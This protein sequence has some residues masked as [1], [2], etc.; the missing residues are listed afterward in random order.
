METNG[1]DHEN[2]ESVLKDDG[3]DGGNAMT[4]DAVTDKV[5]EVGSDAILPQSPY[6][7]SN[8]QK[9]HHTFLTLLSA[10]LKYQ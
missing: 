4:A 10:D 2:V 5:E 6:S 7:A 8:N 9:A 3:I 1:S